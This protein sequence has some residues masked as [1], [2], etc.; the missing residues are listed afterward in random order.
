MD[1]FCI[2]PRCSL[3]RFDFAKNEEIIILRPDGCSVTIPFNTFEDDTYTYEPCYPG[4][5]HWDE[6]LTGYHADCIWHEDCQ[7]VPNLFDATS[8]S[9]DPWPGENVRRLR[10]M[11]SH[12]AHMI[13]PSLAFRLPYEV[14]N[15]VA[16]YCVR[17][18]ALQI[19]TKF[20][21][22]N[23]A[24][25]FRI[26]LSKPV[27][28]RYASLDGVPY[29][30]S[31]ANEPSLGDVV[32]PSQLDAPIQTVHVAEDHLGVREVHIAGPSDKIRDRSQPGL[33]W[34][35][36]QVQGP[37][38]EGRT[39]GSKLRRLICL[40]IGYT[41]DASVLW[42][43]PQ[44]HPERL[45]FTI[46]MKP[47]DP[48]RMTALRLDEKVTGYSFCWNKHVVALK[49]HFPGEDLSYYKYVTSNYPHAL[50]LYIPFY[51]GERITEIW[52]RRRKHGREVAFIAITNIGRIH[53]MGAYPK[54][55]WHP[56]SYE[57]LYKADLNDSP[58]FVDESPAGIHAVASRPIVGNIA[59]RYFPIVSTPYPK[60][61]SYEDYLYTTA[62]V[63]NVARVRLCRTECSSI[64]TGLVFDYTDGHQESV[65][66]TRLDC[67][68]DP[69]AVDVSQKMW[70]RMSRSAWGFPQVVDAG[71]LPISK[72]QG[73]SEGEYLYIMWHGVLEWWFSMNQC[74]LFH[75][76]QASFTTRR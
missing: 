66:Q 43:T 44:P 56:C 25:D 4:C 54:S 74:Q 28:A 34:R 33:W 64:I 24:A 21:Q 37:E 46:L 47:S 35:T 7:S 20:C 40:A 67:L 3:C 32:L 63:D 51:P 27:W 76:G 50:W 65:G 49:A 17:E 6:R 59:K 39:D 23:L 18:Y 11:R 29:I 16:Q 62:R 31:L 57:L 73:E 69:I 55:C 58:F 1:H 61:M 48:L 13:Y 41:P 75:N 10:W 30:V 8:Y 5:Q 12:L 19:S 71:F 36:V 38:L 26:K 2:A 42:D 60:S 15:I 14:C 22:D 70:L 45:R 68:E 52:Q 9:Y 53:L 72:S